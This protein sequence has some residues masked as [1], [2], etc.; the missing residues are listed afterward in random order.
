MRRGCPAFRLEST[1]DPCLASTSASLADVVAHIH[2]GDVLFL[3]SLR[4]PR[5]ANQ[6]GLFDEQSQIEPFLSDRAERVRRE[7]E[8]DAIASL[9]EVTRRRGWVVF[10]GPPPLMHIIPMRCSD[11]F[12]RDNP[13]CER[14]PGGSR[15]LL[16]RMRAPILASYARIAYAVPGVTVWD[17]FPIL[18]PGTEC[19]AYRDGKPLFFDGDHLSGYANAVLLPE[20][21]SFMKGL[22]VDGP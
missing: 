18:C 3:P 16:E 6:W 9:R 21:V 22:P 5:L 17:P 4:L 19:L 7:A 8:K 15:T 20:F 11:W 13:V 1:N 12:N 2:S 14:G 10:E